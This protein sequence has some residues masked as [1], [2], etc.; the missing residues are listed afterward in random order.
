MLTPGD[1]LKRIGLF[2]VGGSLV[3]A[4]LR[5]FPVTQPNEWYKWG[6]EQ[7]N[8]VEAWV[9][10]WMNDVPFDELPPVDSI[11]PSESSGPSQDSPSDEP[12]VESKKSSNKD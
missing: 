4:V 8:S 1:I 3:V 11:I 9:S 10:G 2:F 6:E 7:A 5:G 12:K